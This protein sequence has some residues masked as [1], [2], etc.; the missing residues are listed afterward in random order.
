MLRKIQDSVREDKYRFTVYALERLIERDINPNQVQEAILF[1]KIIEDYPEDK[2]GHSCL[3]CG[4]CSQ[5]TI[6]HVQCSV[7]PVW[8][9]TAYDPTLNPEKWNHSYTKRIK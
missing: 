2:Y 8:I 5:N 1:G 7:D 6:L 9:I 4:W 3:V